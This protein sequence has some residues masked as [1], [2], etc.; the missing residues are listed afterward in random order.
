MPA[1][2]WSINLGTVAAILFGIAGFYFVTRMELKYLKEGH[3]DMRGDIK[4]M[5]EILEKVAV[6]NTRLDHQEGMITAQ[7]KAL[8][9]FQTQLFE[10]A[11]GR[12]W[13]QS[14][15]DGEYPK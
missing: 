1:V 2:E 4:D 15:I 8:T 3:K 14:A 5:K 10:L 6:Q 7:A 13:V 9:N 12:G 11:R